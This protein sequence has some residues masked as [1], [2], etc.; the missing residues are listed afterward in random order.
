[1]RVVLVFA[2]FVDALAL[3]VFANVVL[4]TGRVVDAS[5]SEV[6]ALVLLRRELVSVWRMRMRLVRM[7]IEFDR[8]Y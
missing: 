4:L 2:F 7:I 3:A 1:M 6:Q 8:L 5:S